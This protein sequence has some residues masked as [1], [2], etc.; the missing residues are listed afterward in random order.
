MCL[1]VETG[2]TSEIQHPFGGSPTFTN[3]RP[4]GSDCEVGL[5]P[6]LA[7]KLLN[8]DASAELGYKRGLTHQD[9]Y[10]AEAAWRSLEV[11]TVLVALKAKGA[12]VSHP[13][14][15]WLCLS[16]LSAGMNS[17]HVD[18]CFVDCPPSHFKNYPRLCM[19][20]YTHAHNN[21]SKFARQGYS[22]RA[23]FLEATLL[24]LKTKSF[25][26]FSFP[27]SCEGAAAP[28]AKR[29]RV[30]SKGNLKID[31]AETA[32]EAAATGH[33]DAVRVALEH[34]EKMNRRN[35]QT[36]ESWAQLTA[37][38]LKEALDEKDNELAVFQKCMKSQAK[39]HTK[40]VADAEMDVRHE[41]AEDRS[42]WLAERASL[43]EMSK[44]L[45]RDWGKKVARAEG[46]REE[47]EWAL[48]AKA[49]ENEKLHAMKRGVQTEEQVRLQ[50]EVEKLEAEKLE[51]EEMNEVSS[52]SRAHTLTHC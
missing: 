28:K 43:M 42:V 46:E 39:R 4:F 13:S 33:N 30:Q 23:A 41:Y 26:L 15:L 34:A 16:R 50:G 21:L 9:V 40:E 32:S 27:C 22:T 8:G 47:M 12:N 11:K 35:L 2:A 5:T 6:A 44:E 36:V 17:T 3:A 1:D 29:R 14:F 24:D 37:Q 10:L 20:I 52:H 25:V 51:M 31:G 18:R 48:D 38:K 49:M 7:I 45:S 19:S